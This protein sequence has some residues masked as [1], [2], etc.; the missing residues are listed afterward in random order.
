[1]GV[2][3]GMDAVGRVAGLPDA[4]VAGALD[5]VDDLDVADEGVPGLPVD[6]GAEVPIATGANVVG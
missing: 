1:M 2:L 3:G 4:A 5:G 6:Q